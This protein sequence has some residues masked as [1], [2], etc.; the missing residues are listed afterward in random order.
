MLRTV[1]LAVCFC[2]A[3][4]L[5]ALSFDGPDRRQLSLFSMAQEEEA[6]E[7]PPAEEAPRILH[8][9][10][11]RGFGVSVVGNLALVYPGGGMGLELSLPVHQNVSLT[12]EAGLH[13]NIFYT[14]AHYDI[15]AR[16]FVDF[17]EH[18]ALTLEMGVRLAYGSA[19]AYP[20]GKPD[21]PVRG[22]SVG[23]FM[24]PGLELG[25]RTFRFFCELALN[26][27]HTLDTHYQVVFFNGYNVGFRIYFGAR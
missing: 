23:G 17:T 12:L 8:R 7:T 22:W 18:F 11:D 15:G 27:A 6:A 1:L 26:G 19:H 13:G 25:S 3:L 20:G 14:G 24:N 16:A 2:L 5:S 21:D 10:Y 9:W 4:P